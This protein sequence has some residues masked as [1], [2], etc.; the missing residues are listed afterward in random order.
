MVKNFD[1]TKFFRRAG[2]ILLKG[3][4]GLTIILLLLGIYLYQTNFY[5]AKWE[6]R[7][8]RNISYVPGDSSF[9]HTLD[10]YFPD[11]LEEPAPV[12]AYFHAGA[13]IM[14]SKGTAMAFCA[15][16]LNEGYIIA[17][18]NYRLSADT[19]FPGL[20][21]D[22]KAAIRFLKAHSD[23]YQIDTNRVGAMG[24]SAGGHLAAF[25]GTSSE[26]RELEGYHLGYPKQTSKVQAVADFFGPIDFL[27]MDQNY[28]NNLPRLFTHDA[29]NSPEGKILGCRPSDC[30]ELAAAM[31]P[32]TYIDGNEPPF[33]IAHGKAD[34]IVPYY[35]SQLLHQALTAKGSI[36]QL[37]LFPY[38][39]HGL[40]W[41]DEAVFEMTL[42]FFNQNLKPTEH[43][44]MHR[45]H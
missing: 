45:S 40:F 29:A 22:C 13:F 42:D 39:P 34:N 44:S 36:S 14:G 25:L 8:I 7:A 28:Q 21:Y 31:N 32:I 16:L 18:I 2:R 41:R 10:L 9:R 24:H 17:D 43:W 30:P 23:T 12:I 35:Q 20:I 5:P 33:L 3:I 6:G 11:N 4:L 38:K 19:L 26:A 15:N 1:L 37:E 27:Q